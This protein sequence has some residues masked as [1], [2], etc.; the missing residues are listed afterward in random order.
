MFRPQNLLVRVWKT[1]RFSFKYLFWSLMDPIFWLKIGR[2]SPQISP[3]WLDLLSFV[4]GFAETFTVHIISWRLGCKETTSRYFKTSVAGRRRFDWR[5]TFWERA[6]NWS[7]KDLSQNLINIS[8]MMGEKK[9]RRRRRSHPELKSKRSSGRL[10]LSD[11]NDCGAR[12][13]SSRCCR[14]LW[15]NV[16]QM[17]TE[18]SVT[19]QT[20]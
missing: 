1:P 18:W 7:Q 16:R 14:E 12:C 11:S 6:E 8:Q 10:T 4:C 17:A 19:L 20:Y 2:K 15:V 13:V 5:E 3:V 9:R